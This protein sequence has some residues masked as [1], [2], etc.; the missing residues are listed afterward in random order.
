VRVE[1]VR[2]GKSVVD[3]DWQA[4]NKRVTLHV[5]HT[6]PA[7]RLRW[8]QPGFGKHAPGPAVLERH[9]APG[10]TRLSMP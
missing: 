4:T 8:T 3:L 2:V 5:Y 7:F 1:R 10:K 9:I 6:G